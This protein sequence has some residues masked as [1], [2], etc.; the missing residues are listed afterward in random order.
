LL[1]EQPSIGLIIEQMISNF[2]NSLSF[3]IGA[4]SRT[5]CLLIYIECFSSKLNFG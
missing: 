1:G 2:L 4:P 5:G 3:L